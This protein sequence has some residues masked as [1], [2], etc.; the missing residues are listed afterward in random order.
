MASTR[1]T[2]LA[3]AAPRARWAERIPFAGDLSVLYLP[4][5]LITAGLVLVPLA[6]LLLASLKPSTALPWDAVPLTLANFAAVF[7]API[8][9]TLLANTAI[10]AVGTIAFGLG[11][12]VVLA[13]LVE[14][15][16]VPGRTLVYVAFVV[17]LG[18][19]PMLTALGWTLW[20]SPRIGVANIVLRQLLGSDAAEGPLNG[21]SLGGMIFVT[22]L[23]ICP[24]IFMMIA[25]LLRNMD[26]ALEDAGQMSGANTS[27][28]W[29][30]ITLPLL[31]P[32]LLATVTYYLVT[33]IQ[34]FDVPL[35]LGL[36][37][38]TLV[39]ST[40][41]FLLTQPENGLPEYGLAATYA[42]IA[43]IAGVLLMVVYLRA[44]RHAERFRIVT[45]K[46]YRP[47]RIR[48]GR[49]K[50]PALAFIGGYLLLALVAPLVLLLW[51][52]LLP[53]YQSPSWE[54]LSQL[55]LAAYGEVLRNPRVGPAALNTVVLM[56]AAA[57]LAT[58]LSVLI[59]WVSL[60]LRVR[61]AR[62]LE[63][64]AFSAL[65]I[66]SIV[67]ALAVLLVY[68]RTPIYGTVWI[69]VVGHLTT[70][71]SFGTRTMSAAVIQLHRELEESAA[72]HG[73][74][75]WATL[76]RV[77]M[78]LLFPAMTNGWIWMAAHSMRDF[79]FPLMLGTSGNLVI[80]ALIWNFWRVP[81][82]PAAAALSVMLA[83]ALGACAGLSRAY[84]ISR[85]DEGRS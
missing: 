73:A 8:T 66:P 5:L 11:C 61:G 31:L 46:G 85:A 34:H 24:S 45:G 14:R 1:A 67:V 32:G 21:Y 20:L 37:G 47:R 36:P 78:P 35:A 80:A 19:P 74:S 4:L 6:V 65:A 7:A 29:R 27:S 57:T 58:I 2:Q 72:V 13:W 12:A 38:R 77:V 25:A 17:A 83:V 40:R 54:A 68:I 44:T 10:Y 79:T 51:I 23:A 70:Y 75:W 16:D 41:V 71:L 69:L 55:S 26:A 18:L 62:L 64:L 49:W 60:R 84:L 9:Y 82:L 28:V 48:L 53:Y 50:Y 30:R 76:R 42:V 63:S 43:L 56:V 81:N 59:A 22:G 39:L 3:R 52:S 15:T 33:L